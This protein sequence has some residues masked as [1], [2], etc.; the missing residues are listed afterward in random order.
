M[1]RGIWLR[2][3]PCIRGQSSH[4][5]IGVNIFPA[6]FVIEGRVEG[7][8]VRPSAKDEQLVG[9][10]QGG[11]ELPSRKGSVRCGG[12]GVRGREA[13]EGGS[14]YTRGAHAEHEVHAHGAGR[15]EAQR[16]VESRRFLPS[17]KQGVRC[18]ARCA[19]RKARELG[20]GAGAGARGGPATGGLRAERAANVY[21][22]GGRGVA[23]DASSAR[24]G[25]GWRAVWGPRH[26]RRSA[27]RTCG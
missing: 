15:V 5:L 6:L 1:L 12:R 13:G 7:L 22:P 25:P 21:N 3:S 9:V 24:G 27:R 14:G 19:G 18:R 20:R 26:A 10:G 8:G 11:C 17:R 2:V 4:A 16:L 23:A